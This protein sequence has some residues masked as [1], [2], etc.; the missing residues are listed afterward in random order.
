MLIVFVFKNHPGIGDNIRGLITLLQVVDTCCKKGYD[1]NVIEDFSES[2]IAKYL[3]NTPSK[4]LYEHIETHTISTDN[5]NIRHHELEAFLV[6]KMATHSVLKLNTN[7]FPIQAEI[8]EGIKTYIKDILQFSDSFLSTASKY[9]PTTS[10]TPYH[11]FHYRFGDHVFERRKNTN[12]N[13]LTH[14]ESFLYK[15][16]TCLLISDCLDFKK[17]VSQHFA[18]S[19]SNVVVHLT[20]PKH[21]YQKEDENDINIFIDFFL[22]MNSKS[23]SCYSNYGWISNFVLWISALYDIPLRDLKQ[24]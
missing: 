24:L 5:E 23:I 15:E 14:F 17:R 13:L 4:S 11:L 2:K 7:F 22:I 1:I 8:T 9:I 18:D 21:T 12:S 16:E 19:S 3:K 20:T 10:K 6:N